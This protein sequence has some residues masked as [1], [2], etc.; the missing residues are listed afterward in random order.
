MGCFRTTGLAWV[1]AAEAAGAPCRAHN[2]H[3]DAYQSP[4]L[5]AKASSERPLPC[6][7]S[8][9]DRISSD[10]RRCPFRRANGGFPFTRLPCRVQPI[11]SRPVRLTITVEAIKCPLVP[12]RPPYRSCGW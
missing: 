12:F 8:R 1:V 3:S 4:R 9:I 7:Q 2:R 6:C 11:T 5:R 10:V